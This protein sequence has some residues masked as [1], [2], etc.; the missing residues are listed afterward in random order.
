MENL[1]NTVN[2]GNIEKNSC[3]KKKGGNG[4]FF[5][6]ALFIAIAVMVSSAILAYGFI[7]YKTSGDNDIKAT[8]SAS[9]DFESDLIV[10]RGNFSQEATTS[11]IAYEKIKNDAD[12]VKSYLLKQG[13]S[14]KE[15]VFSSVDV[16]RTTE[17]RYND[18]GNY[19]GSYYTGYKLTQSI[20]VT[21]SKIDAVEE[22]SRNISTLLE[23]GVEF[24]SWSPEYYKTNLD[25]VKM[26]LIGMAT[27]NAKER[28]DI[29]AQASGATIGRLKNSELGVIQITA[30]NSG[31]SSY[32]YDGAFDTG[33]RY[34]TATIT[35]R[36]D[37]AVK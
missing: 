35:V 15:I 30:Q 2:E 36:L 29:M 31:T 9:L 18:E 11:R 28:I 10:W 24:E 16:S 17:D 13:L 19:I 25:D 27:E 5:L 20:T 21:S 14:E 37:Y 8:G 22:I 23:S 34:K 1:E 33:S 26:E 3:A 32:S 7:Y 12:I 4:L 6:P